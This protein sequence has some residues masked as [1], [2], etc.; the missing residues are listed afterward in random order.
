MIHQILKDTFGY[1][2]FR[3][4]Q[5]EAI[6]AVLNKQDVL[7]VLPTGG[8]KSICFQIPALAQEGLSLVISPLIALMNDQVMALN[9][10]GIKAY[11]F[12]SNIDYETK[13]Q[14][15]AEIEQGLVKLL[16][17]SPEGLQQERLLHYLSTKTINL[18]AVDEAHCVSMWGNDFRPDYVKLAALKTSFLG[19]PIMAVTAT[20]D[21]LTQED[22]IKKLNLESPEKFVGSFERSNITIKG[23]P[24]VDR[25]NQIKH[26]LVK[27]QQSAG[28]IYSTSRKSTEMLS[29]KLKKDGFAAAHYHAGLDRAER[30]QVHEDF[31]YDRINIVCA[32]IAFGMGI[33]KS[34]I[35]YVIHYNL[36][37]N[38]ESYYQ[39][40]GRAGRDGSEA[41]ALVF[42]SYA[43]ITQLKRFIDESDADQSY[44]IL[45]H[46]KLDQMWEF[47]NTSHCR[48]NIILNYFGEFKNQACLH[49][50]NCIDP[51]ETFD[52]TRF[53]QMALSAVSRTHE[54]ISIPVLIDILRGSG[55]R[56]IMENGFQHIKT[57]GVGRDV[58]FADWRSY[59]TQMIQQGF[60]KVDY[61]DQTKLK[62][63][64]L[65]KKVLFEQETVKL[66]KFVWKEK[67]KAK[68]KVVSKTDFDVDDKLFDTLRKLRSQIANEQG[69]PAYVIFPN[70]TL[71]ELS[72]VKPVDKFAFSLINGVGKMKLEKYSE[73]FIQEIQNYVSQN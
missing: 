52:G 45:Q 53:T 47:A 50:D 62:L 33:D 13:Q 72:S 57:Y 16:Y 71:E 60:M 5:Q 11:S 20:A 48:T 44:K 61:S 49:C 65:A 30:E 23:R 55:R 28:I 73:A 14:M 67:S 36:S 42:Y 7:L 41:E 59:L 2:S 70:K 64:P 56:E 69:V 3:P 66:V 1:S 17:I 37:K 8:G 9:E 51:P 46:A 32:T 22:I 68:P 27:H 31:I 40:I 4:F 21:Q 34:N 35:R 43:D 10:N 19:V 39:E 15:F 58:P 38:I 24:G 54:K 63:T 26:F 6:E 29:G 12:H 25:Y 18:I